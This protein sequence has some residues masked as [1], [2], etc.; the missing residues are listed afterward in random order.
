MRGSLISLGSDFVAD[1]VVTVTVVGWTGGFRREGNSG[2]VSSVVAE[3]VSIGRAGLGGRTPAR[4][5]KDPVG[6]GR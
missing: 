6:A 4:R 3:G 1:E 5:S 2:A